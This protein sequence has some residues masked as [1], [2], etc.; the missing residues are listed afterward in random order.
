MARSKRIGILTGGG[1]VPGLN[2]VIKSV[3]YRSTSQQGYEVVGIRRGWEG[4]THV[5]PAD[6]KGHEY[7]VPLDRTNT[8]IID[9]TGGT[10]LHTSRTNPIRMPL[11]KLPEHVQAQ[12]GKLRE[13]S[14]GIVDT[15]PI[16][17][18]NLERLGIDYLVA[19]GGDDTLSYASVLAKQGIPI[20]AVPK[21][22]DN[23]VQNTEY[24]VGFSTAMTRAVDAITRVRTTLGSHERIGVFRIFGR[25]AGFTALYAAYVASVRCC[26]PEHEFNL[27]RLVDLLV[28]D[29]R[30]NPSRYALVVMSEGASWVGRPVQ[31][32]GE[33]DLFGHRKKVSVAEA[34]AHEMEKRSGEQSVIVDLTYE[35]R[36]G[37]PDFLDKMVA[38]AFATMAFEC[39]DA[40][41]KNRMTA[42]KNGC[43]TDTEIPDPSRGPRRVDVENMYDTDR[44]RPDYATKKDLPIFMMKA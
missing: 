9:R 27:D 19:I 40:G 44:F 1:D 18:E 3:V 41:A 11:L 38:T 20:V 39:L 10:F 4:L 25:D 2:A 29:K 22:M 16:V 36:S 12:A 8:R 26:I 7:L 31:E 34:F 24:C 13:V 14:N 33:A 35:L 6:P 43:Y 37:D 28:A 42:V 5:N 23:D 30:D 17:L 32:Y 21:T 15:T